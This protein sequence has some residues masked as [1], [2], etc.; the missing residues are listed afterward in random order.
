MVELMARDGYSVSSACG[1]DLTA[2]DND[3]IKLAV[4][5]LN[6]LDWFKG[7]S[8]TH[9]KPK[10]IE[11]NPMAS[12]HIPKRLTIGNYLGKLSTTHWLQTGILTYYAMGACSTAGAGDP[13]TH[14]ITKNTSETPPNLAFHFE[15]TGT[16]SSRLKDCVGVGNNRVVI[17]VSEASPI[18][19][20]TFS[21]DFACSVP[22]DDVTQPTALVQATNAPYNWFDLFHASSSTAFTYNTGAINVQIVSIEM[23]IGWSGALFGPFDASGFPTDCHNT[24]PFDTYVTLGVRYTDAGGTSIEAISDLDHE[25]YAGDLDLI[26]DFY[27]GAN[28]YIEY[29]WDDMYIVPDSFEEVFMSEDNWYDGATFTLKFRNETSSLAVEEKNDIAKTSYEN[30]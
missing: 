20:Q 19:E 12:T 3:Q 28:D 2:W 6:A 23:H 30:D 5:E 21:C 16:T 10:T 25:S 13:Y 9:T 26:V 24:P 8:I 11:V 18:A 17:S 14:T 1:T 29:T 4:A 22:A 7:A 15:K 27:K